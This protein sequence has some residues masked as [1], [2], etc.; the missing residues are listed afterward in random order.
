M[1][2]RTVAEEAP[3]WAFIAQK[4]G[5]PEEEKLWDKYGGIASYLNSQ[6]TRLISD[7]KTGKI[8]LADFNIPNDVNFRGFLNSPHLDQELC[9]QLSHLL[10]GANERGK[11]F[12]EEE[13]S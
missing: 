7:I 3:F 12:S 11:T 4:I 8:S 9:S 10:Y 13:K 5:K 1:K 2:K 6:I